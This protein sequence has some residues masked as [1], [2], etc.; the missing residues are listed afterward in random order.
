[1]YLSLKR[2]KQELGISDFD[3]SQDVTLKNLILRVEQEID[4]YLAPQPV[5]SR[6]V[7]HRFTG[8]G[9]RSVYLPFTAVSSLTSVSEEDQDGTLIAMTDARLSRVDGAWY[10]VRRDGFFVK[11]LVYEGGFTAGYASSEVPED[12]VQS[13]NELV[14]L[15]YYDMAL[16]NGGSRFGV[17][18]VSVHA[19]TGMA[20]TTVYHPDI[21]R[22][23]A[24]ER[25]QRYRPVIM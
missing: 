6:A 3:S 4:S 5:E 10:L 21:V 13:G 8:R 9:L 17:G 11:G 15:F 7:I 12:I 1:M 20:S 24:Y 22:A 18:Q 23:K 14:R 25:L 2:I 19:G 16:E